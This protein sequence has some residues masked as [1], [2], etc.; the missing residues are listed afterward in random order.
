YTLL[1]L[2]LPIEGTPQE[3]F[4]PLRFRFL[5]DSPAGSPVM[6]GHNEGVITINVAEA[7]DAERERRRVALHEPFRTLLGHLRHEIAHYYW[8]V[9]MANTSH[10]NRFRALFGDERC[11]YTSAL[12]NY[13]Q[14]SAP[15][16]WQS[17]HVSAY[18][19]AHPWEDWAETSA[20]YLH[21]VDTVETAASFGLALKPKHPDAKAMTADPRKALSGDG[22]FNRL[23]ENWLPLT[24]ALNELNRGMGLPDLYPFVL[25]AV[26]IEKLQFVHDVL[27]VRAN[28]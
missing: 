4:P 19:A 8:N 9:L 1:R 13:Y 26:A 20:H 28:N 21:I 27:N 16:D 10:L 14:Q 23:L 7:D 17:R 12:Q 6:T 3:N 2:R 24:Y 11:D 22:S 25:S 5:S 18:A 15:A